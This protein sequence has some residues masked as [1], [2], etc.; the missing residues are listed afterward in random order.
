MAV[1][2]RK[3][4]ST[5]S[6]GLGL[7][8]ERVRCARI[9]KKFVHKEAHK[10]DVHFAKSGQE[11]VDKSIEEGGKCHLSSRELHVD[12]PDLSEPTT[13]VKEE[14]MIRSD[15][16]PEKTGNFHASMGTY[17]YEAGSGENEMNIDAVWKSHW[18]P[19]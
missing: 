17:Q 5:V 6:P 14:G 11:K 12:P 9:S 1:D 2:G 19:G 10:V 4:R 8:E 7:K 15:H 16:R 18:T 3:N 13:W